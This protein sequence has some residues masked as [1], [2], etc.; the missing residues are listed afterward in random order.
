MQVAIG[1]VS[2]CTHGTAQKIALDRSP[3]IHR[4]CI[5]IFSAPPPWCCLCPILISSS[6]TIMR[7]QSSQSDT[8]GHGTATYLPS[9][10]RTPG[11]KLKKPMEWIKY[12]QWDTR[13]LSENTPITPTS[14][15]THKSAQFWSRGIAGTW[16]KASDDE[17]EMAQKPH[18]GSLSWNLQ[19]RCISFL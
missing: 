15:T 9:G 10:W 11:L 2:L 5:Y 8:P 13:A 1:A 14:L 7:L 18:W 6:D 17:T 19:W 16:R 3:S 12:V 4:H